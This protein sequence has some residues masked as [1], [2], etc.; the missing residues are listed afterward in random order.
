MDPILIDYILDG[1]PTR[2]PNAYDTKIPLTIYDNWLMAVSNSGLRHAV[3]S[4]AKGFPFIRLS[5]DDGT[6][7]GEIQPVLLPGCSPAARRLCNDKHASSKM[8]SVS[9]LRVP[10]EKQYRPS[11][12]AA[13]KR[14]AFHGEESVAVKASS[15]SLGN[16]VYL[17]VTEQAFDDAFDA[18]VDA[19]AS[20]NI[21]PVVLVQEMLTGFE[22]RVTVIEGRAHNALVRIPAYVHGDG[23]RTVHE[24]VAAKNRSRYPNYF[25]RNKLIRRDANALAE[26]RRQGMQLDSVPEAGQPVLL[27]S[28]SNVTYGGE[29]AVITELVSS[30]ILNAAE[31]AVTAIPGLYTA[32]VDIIAKTF[33]DKDPIVLEL[34]SFPHMH[35]SLYPYYGERVDAQSEFLSA[36]IKRDE[37]FNTRGPAKSLQSMEEWLT[38]MAR[39]EAMAERRLTAELPR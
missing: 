15:L 23:R 4:N 14:A 3:R 33:D 5:R 30:Q 27:S 34:N 12:K 32:G 31:D 35:L 36:I 13:A 26:L 11:E 37:A 2:V 39:K 8:L 25:F 22:I 24:L 1:L 29:T 7:L 20:A 10:V 19:Q 38:V 18:C 28:V 16:G 21:A 9:G 6:L 17:N